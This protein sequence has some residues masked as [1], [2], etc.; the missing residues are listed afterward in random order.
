MLNCI[1]W[2]HEID[3]LKLVY[4]LVKSF[5]FKSMIMILINHRQK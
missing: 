2:V 5:F 4:D 3:I 1:N